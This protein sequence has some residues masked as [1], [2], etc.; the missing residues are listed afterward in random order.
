MN[1]G[2]EYKPV[3]CPAGRSSS[4]INRALPRISS[5][6][7]PLPL[8]ATLCSSSGSAMA[9]TEVESAPFVDAPV[10]AEPSIEEVAIEAETTVEEPKEKEEEAA[11]PQVTEA[12]AEPEDTAAE[13]P[14]VEISE[15]EVAVDPTTEEAEPEAEP[16]EAAPAAEE[17]TKPA[18]EEPDVV[19]K[20][21]TSVV[22]EV[23]AEEPAAEEV[24]AS[25]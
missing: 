13:A 19:E 10:Y 7:I 9:S 1:T 11:D 2:Q 17:T 23:T 16:E 12:E 25:E 24:A 22:E 8:A 21:A 4:C 20:A 18:A 6:L 15:P 14:A 3:K 5:S